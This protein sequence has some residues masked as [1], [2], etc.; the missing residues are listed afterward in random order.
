MRPESY[1][2]ADNKLQLIG[3]KN[4]VFGD[5]QIFDMSGRVL[6]KGTSK[7]SEVQIN[8]A[9]PKGVYIITYSDKKESKKFVNN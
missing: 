7:T 3:G 1:T 6:Q 5:Y 4:A 9:L 8:Q 2:K